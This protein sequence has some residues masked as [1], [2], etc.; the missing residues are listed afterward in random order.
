MKHVLALLDVCASDAAYVGDEASDIQT[1]KVTDMRTIGVLTGSETRENLDAAKADYVI[2]D[3][4][5][6]CALL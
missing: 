5:E 3:V 1:G 2:A 4:R 6:I